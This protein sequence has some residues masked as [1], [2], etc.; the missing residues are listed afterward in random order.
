MLIPIIPTKRSNRHKDGGD[1]GGRKLKSGKSNS[2][3]GTTLDISD[4]GGLSDKANGKAATY[5]EGGEIPI[6]V[7]GAHF[8][9]SGDDDVAG[10]QVDKIKY[11]LN[12]LSV[13][14]F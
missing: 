9:G 6:E 10:D 4:V 2:S 1:G 3:S 8:N 12:I 11:V 5:S 13:T 14:Y 7:E